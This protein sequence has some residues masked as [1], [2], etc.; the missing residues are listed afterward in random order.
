MEVKVFEIQNYLKERLDVFLSRKLNLSRTLVKRYI[1]GKHI[2]INENVVKP[3]YKLK[4]GDKIRICIPVI[5]KVN[6]LPENISLDIIYTD[7]D[8]IVIN[9]PPDMVVHPGCGRDSKTL[10]NAL[11]YH[12][13]DLSGIGGFLRPGIVHRL[14]KDTSGLMVVAKN[15]K[16]HQYLSN[17]FKE[18]KVV[19][20][21]L[22]LVQGTFKERSGEINIAIGRSIKDRKKIGVFSRKRKEAITFFRVLS[23]FKNSTLLEVTT[24][25][26]RT[27]QIR[28]HLS[29]IHHPVIGDSIYGKKNKI[30]NRQALHCHVLG[31]F[32]P[33]TKKYVEFKSEMPNDMK[34]AVEI[35]KGL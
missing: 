16:A 13:K 20:K 15:D 33:A 21:Y 11:L 7:N 8:I 34:K 23:T 35:L 3:S 24:K 5:K 9:K 19:K 2:Q 18:R 29:Y 14:D 17:Q 4:K 26:G 10:V 6:V 27:H 28:V 22:S 32:H 31:F 1:F 25:T 30:I 12:C